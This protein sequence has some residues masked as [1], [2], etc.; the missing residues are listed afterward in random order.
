MSDLEGKAA[1]TPGRESNT[2]EKQDDIQVR[3]EEAQQAV[4][5]EGTNLD[6]VGKFLADVATRPDADILLAPWTREEERKM[7]KRKVDPIIMTI[8]LLTCGL[9][10]SFKPARTSDTDQATRCRS[11]MGAVDKASPVVCLSLR[12]SLLK[13]CLGFGATGV[14]WFG[15]CPGLA[16]R[17]R[18][19]RGQILLVFVHFILCRFCAVLMPDGVKK[20][21]SL[22]QGAIVTVIPTMLLM[23]RFPAAKY[24]AANCF[25]WGILMIAMIGRLILHPRTRK[26]RSRAPMTGCKS[27]AT[28][29]VVRFILG[30][31]ESVIFAGFG[32]I[33]VMWWKS[34][35]QSWR[36]AVVFSTLSSVMNALLSI[37]SANYHSSVL[38]QWQLLFLLVGIITCLLAVTFW[39]LVP[40]SPTTAW[41]LSDRE[42]VIAVKRLAG[43][44]TGVE[45]K[46]LKWSQVKEA[47]LDPKTYFFFLINVSRRNRTCSRCRVES[48]D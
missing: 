22:S 18:S 9:C 11:M 40:D 38:A 2:N 35:E 1:H 39:W 6:V 28:V 30:M 44:R 43:N 5:T 21:D 8:L 27:F 26:C 37:A 20:T 16:R 12:V 10:L 31:F 32:L 46:Q 36:T 45:N 34:K 17:R 47:F 41:W 48:N 25:V 24:I 29:A 15:S 4:Q 19:F 3:A 23:Q 13:R 42:K 33:V 7:L 14:H